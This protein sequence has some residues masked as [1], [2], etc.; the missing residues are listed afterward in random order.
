L[1]PT[2]CAGSRDFAGGELA[3]EI[4]RGYADGEV[5]VGGGR[6]TGDVVLGVTLIV[7][8]RGI[9]LFRSRCSET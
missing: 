7:D 4:G 8:G 1:S 5:G 6:I 3:E 2:G 9:S